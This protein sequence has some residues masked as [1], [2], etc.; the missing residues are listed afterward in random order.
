MDGSLLQNICIAKLRVYSH[1]EDANAEHFEL[2]MALQ[3]KLR[4]DN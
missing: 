2:G 1:A 3:E 4:G